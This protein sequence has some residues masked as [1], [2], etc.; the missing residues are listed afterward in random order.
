MKTFVIIC[1]FIVMVVLAISPLF[2]LWIDLL[3][4]KSKKVYVVIWRYDAFC[5]PST[6]L[7]EAKSPYDAWREEEWTNY[8][9]KLKKLKEGF[10][11]LYEHYPH[12]WD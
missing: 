7:V 4:D 12:F 5:H 10:V 8:K 6:V 3:R 1:L 2:P 11:L 9:N